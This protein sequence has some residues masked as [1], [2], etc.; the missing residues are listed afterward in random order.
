[1]ERQRLVLSRA[2]LESQ[3]KL[4]ADELQRQQ[5]LLEQNLEFSL[6]SYREFYARRT[7]L[8]QAAID[9]TIRN[10]ETELGQERAALAKTNKEDDRIPLLVKIKELETQ[11]IILRKQRGDVEVKAD[12]DATQSTL[13]LLDSLDQVRE[14]LATAK[15]DSASARRS[16]LEREFTP[17]VAQFQTILDD[18]GATLV[19]KSA[20]KQGIAWIEN[21]IN[22]DVAK[23]RLNEFQQ[24][25]DRALQQMQTEETDINTQREAGLIGEIEARQRIIDLHR[26]TAE[27]MNP[28]IQKLREQADLIRKTMPEAAAAIDRTVAESQRLAQ[29]I[30]E[31]AQRI[32]NSVRG[33][34]ADAFTDF[35]KGAKSAKEAFQSFANS[36][37]AAMQRILAEK[38][39][40][41][42]FTGF[43]MGSIGNFFSAAVHH[44]GG[45]VGAGGASR[46][47]SPLAFIGA[48]RYHSG[49]IAGLKSDEVPAILQ[50]GERVLSRDQVRGMG[51]NNVKVVIENKGTPQ[52][53]TD[54]QVTFDPEAMI[55]K[56]FIDDVHRGGPA[57]NT[58]ARA[59]NLRRGGG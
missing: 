18:A 41:E 15:G 28:V 25:Y 14:R 54:S 26:R 46:A 40:S 58:L 4:V 21:F 48:P 36:V 35:I 34:M 33:G 32:N 44:G 5:T 38:M 39:A 17:Q 50:S 13:K 42:I 2:G 53:V 57:S 56:V 43:N 31:I 8:Q 11:L 12:F 29:P 9:Q 22:L 7:Q 49:G 3:T 51:A 45:V 59:F 55:V 20:A 10:T 19:Q 16:A 1:L 24:L 37:V 23:T 27:A 30:D 47:V 52:Q 6:V